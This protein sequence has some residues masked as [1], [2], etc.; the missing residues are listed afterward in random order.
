MNYARLGEWIGERVED[1]VGMGVP[2]DEAESLMKSVEYG[3]IAAEAQA[4]SDDQFMLDL[5]RAGVAGMV[6]RTRLTRQAIHK[7]KTKINRR[8]TA[9]LTG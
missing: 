2:R 6:D 1:L 4:R 9:R 7:R 5:K 3:A 8:L